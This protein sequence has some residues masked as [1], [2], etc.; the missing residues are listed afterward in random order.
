MP[1]LFK[2]YDPLRWVVKPHNIEKEMLTMK[3]TWMTKDGKWH[4]KTIEDMEERLDFIS[5]LETDP[6]VVKWK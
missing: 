5:W 3:F 4:T 2:E 1:N 6:S